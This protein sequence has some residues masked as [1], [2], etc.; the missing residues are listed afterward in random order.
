MAKRTYAVP[1]PIGCGRKT[2]TT[3]SDGNGENFADNNP[4][5]GTPGD[6]EKED[7]DANEGNHGLDGSSVVVLGCASGHTNNADNELRND[8]AHR[9]VDEDGSSTESF[10]HPEGQRGR[11]GV[12]EAGDEGN[13]EWIADRAERL[14]EDGPKVEDEVDTCQ[15][16]H[17]LH[18]DTNGGTTRVAATLQD[19]PFEAV[20]PSSDVTGLGNDLHLIFMVRHDLRQFILNVFGFH[21]LS[22]H[23]AQSLG[24]FLQLAL[25]DKVP[26]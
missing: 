19:I 6:G 3:G 15:L 25:F 20:G 22:S 21:G 18:Q 4:R 14:E 13:Q 8:H 17:H 24:S 2:D 16:L 11:A 7:V 10:N 9:T 23:R 5:G 12:D 1:K 26:W